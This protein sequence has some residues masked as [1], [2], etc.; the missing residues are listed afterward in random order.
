MPDFKNQKNQKEEWILISLGGSI[1]IPDQID[2]FFLKEFRN[3]ISRWILKGKKFIIVV[4]GGK[5]ARN[6]Q[7]AAGQFGVKDQ[8]ML[9]VIGIYA[10]YL[11]AS[12]VRSVFFKT[13]YSKI[14]QDP[15]H[16][17][18]TNKKI[19]VFAGWK[20]GRST[21]F[22]AVYLGNLYKI[23]EVVNL[24]NI[25]YVYDKDPRKYKNAKPIKEI[26]LA[27]ALKLSGGKWKAGLNFPFG[28]PALKLAQKRD[29]KIVILKGRNLKNLDNYFKNK[30]FKGTTIQK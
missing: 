16:K 29:I 27:K 26:S 4:G 3:F 7:K 24:S 21:D 2:K 5:I 18:K 19:I 28:P 30:K 20:P 14:I 23:K 1:V 11:N 15:V 13:A 12:L 8:D 10:T 9:D 22:V 17:I 25:D 6:Y